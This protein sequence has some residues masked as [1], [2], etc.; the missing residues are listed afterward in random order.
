MALNKKGWSSYKNL[1]A[2]IKMTTLKQ[3]TYFQLIFATKF[4]SQT[5][6]A[7]KIPLIALDKLHTI[8][9]ANDKGYQ[10]KEKTNKYKFIL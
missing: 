8:L 7:T 4:S 2:M 6:F 9:V 3:K 1:D 10:M 5:I